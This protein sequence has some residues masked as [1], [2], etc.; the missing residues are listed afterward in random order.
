MNIEL[1]NLFTEVITFLLLLWFLR[2]VAWKPI[3][4]MLENRQQ[5]IEA[6]I[7]TAESNKK[8][9]ERLVE[10]QRQML[11]RA[12][13][14]A[15]EMIEAA[16]RSGDRQAAEILTLA[17]SESKRIRTEAVAE[18]EREKQLALAA[19][20]EYVADLTV[21]ISSRVLARDLDEQV[22]AALVDEAAKELENS[23]C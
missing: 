18:I 3:A 15:H 2:A 23:V 17:E 21:R 5:H 8:E 14:E 22:K 19:V 16:R 11:E 4:K 12:K 20:S 13:Q 9:S 7:D 1:G 10:E 6:Q